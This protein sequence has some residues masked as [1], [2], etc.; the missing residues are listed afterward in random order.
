MVFWA[1]ARSEL[2][3]NMFRL[4]HT[5]PV[6]H[7]VYSLDS[8]LVHTASTPPTILEWNFEKN[9]FCF[10]LHDK[11]VLVLSQCWTKAVIVCVFMFSLVVKRLL[12][13]CHLS[14]DGVICN[15]L[16][17]FLG[18][19]VLFFFS[20]R[21]W[22]FR[23]TFSTDPC[24]INGWMKVWVSTGELKQ[25]L[26]DSQPSPKLSLWLFLCVDFHAGLQHTKAHNTHLWKDRK[27]NKG[28]DFHKHRD[29]N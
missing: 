12:L 19:F 11:I 2:V 23:P 6:L 26:D 13:T 4:V 17:L 18:L 8:C 14:A 10:C 15:G 1:D 7:R 16:V 22:A 27:A 5:F 20:Q 24:S 25:H 3:Q 28:E 21:W 29:C 9:P